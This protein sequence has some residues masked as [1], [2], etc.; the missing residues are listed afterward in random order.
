MPLLKI[1]LQGD[2]AWPD[3]ADRRDDVVHLANDAPP[4]QVSVLDDGMESGAPSV[5]IRIDLPDGTI[6]I[7]E[8]SLRLFLNAANLLSAAYPGYAPWQMRGPEA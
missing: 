8:T 7:A 4:I 2:G 1:L 6:V 5:S 3:L